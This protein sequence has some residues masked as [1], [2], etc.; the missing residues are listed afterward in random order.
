[1]AGHGDDGAG[2]VVHRLT[3]PKKEEGRLLLLYCQQRA[4]ECLGM[5]GRSLGS[6]HLAALSVR[7]ESAGMEEKHPVAELRMTFKCKIND[8]N[9]NSSILASL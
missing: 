4:L 1:M 7:Y 6:D 2:S 9:H 5:A 8:S 3:S